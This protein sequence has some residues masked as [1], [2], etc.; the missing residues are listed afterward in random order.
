M[1]PP[2]PLDGKQGFDKPP[3]FILSSHGDHYVTVK[4]IH[5][6]MWDLEV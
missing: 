3:V 2:T 4:R 6:M 5:Q 1:L